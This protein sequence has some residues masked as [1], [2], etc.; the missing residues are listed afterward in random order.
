MKRPVAFL[1]ACVAA[2]SCR[3]TAPAAP[4]V[5]AA[6]AAAPAP[7]APPLPD[8]VFRAGEPPWRSLGLSGAFASP[9]ATEASL[10]ALSRKLELPTSFGHALADALASGKLGPGGVIVGRE[11]LDRVDPV[12]PVVFVVL[13]PGIGISAGTCLGVSFRDAAGARRT[14][15]ELGVETA[16]VGGESTRRLPN[17]LRVHAGVHGRTLLFSTDARFI[18]VAGPLVEALQARGAAHPATLSVYPQAL[19]VGPAVLGSAVEAVLTKALRQRQAKDAAGH[20]PPA[21]TPSITDGLVAAARVAA[22]LLGS[23][24]ADT[25]EAR[26]ELDLDERVGVALRFV[27]EPVEGSALARGLAPPAPARLDPRF[28]TSDGNVVAAWGSPVTMTWL[29]ALFD[30]SGP[31]GKAFHADWKAWRRLFVGPGSCWGDVKLASATTVCAQPLARGAKP[32]DLLRRYAAFDK[33]TAAWVRELGA[34]L[35]LAAKVRLTRDALEITQ[36]MDVP[37][38]PAA[39]RARRHELMGGAVRRSVMMVQ[40]KSELYAWAPDRAAAAAAFAARAA[41]GAPPTPALAAVLTRAEGA[42]VVVAF[43][44][45][46]VMMSGLE[47]TADARMR[48]ALVML[49]GVRGFADLHAPFGLT[50]RLGA[51]AAFELHFPLETL[52]NVADIMRPYMGVMGARPAP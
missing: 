21:G 29:D 38:E 36:E 4:P 51:R 43:D 18:S 28:R 10:D 33:D 16:R 14:L 9:A 47:L 42:D 22:R 48:S 45:V 41:P 5:T 12:L 50:A 23:A 1:C 27:V 13:A 32:A 35:P 34:P 11:T 52:R 31:A 17:G 15:D 19:P 49:N 8:L 24:I 25:R 44:L 26:L 20:A 2:A 3:A 30:A 37:G 7:P 6:R 40:P 39:V 46:P